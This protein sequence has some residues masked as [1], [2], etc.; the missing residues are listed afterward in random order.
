MKYKILGKQHNTDKCFVCGMLNKA[1]TKAQFYNCEI[2]GGEKILL[3]V[4]EPQAIHQSY[5]N[6]MHGG[7]ISALMDES[8][9]RAVQVTQPETWAVTIDLNVKFRSPA[10]L[11]QTLYIES[12]V[13]NLGARA[14]E[15]EAKMTTK[16]GRVL[17]TATAKYFIVNYD[18]LFATEKLT[19]KTWFIVKED[20]PKYITIGA[21]NENFGG[22]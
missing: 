10:P 5:P 4:I 2:E 15:G 11:D 18:V 7:V 6:R 9:G 13:T 17:A 20:L 14:F 8:I 16:N 3:T 21:Q 19:S 12:R 1:G 22:I